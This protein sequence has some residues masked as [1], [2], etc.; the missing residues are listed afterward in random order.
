MPTSTT[1]MTSSMAWFKALLVLSLSHG[2]TGFVIIPAR[3]GRHDTT[4]LSAAAPRMPRDEVP[5]PPE[6]SASVTEGPLTF[7]DSVRDFFLSLTRL[8]LQDYEWRSSYFKSTEADRMLEESL[9]RMQGIR[10]PY[11]RPMDAAEDRMGP[12]GRWEKSSVE[13]L[14]SVIDEEGRR[15]KKIVSNQGKL[16]RPIETADEDDA[17]LG[18]LGF[19][20]QQASDFLNNI[21]QSE[22]ERVRTKT[23]QPKDLP[24]EIRGP[25]GAMEL[26]VS[27]FLREL[28][29][30]EKLRA[31]QSKRRG[32]AMVR[33]IDVPGPLGE[34]E[35]KVAD[36]LRAEERRAKLNRNEGR[37]VR[38]KDA[39]YKGPLGEAEQ[40]IYELFDQLRAE[41]NE[42]LQNIQQLMQDKRPMETDRKS[43]LGV[44]EA[45][46]VG[47]IRAPQLFMSVLQ[48]V[49]ELL[50][51]QP[52]PEE[53]KERL[54]D[55]S[56]LKKD[57]PSQK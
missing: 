33:P 1:T 4:F 55:A 37:V 32:G 29:E 13:W 8:S 50:N 52:L 3:G 18:P 40:F 17:S 24:E 49:G 10:R 9:A 12:L 2:G 48:R 30:S 14:E 53:D 43:A 39:R 46:V 35:L 56:P 11:V 28:R 27:R 5:Q 44:A 6:A 57:P 20:E 38:P 26:T 54:R 21:R 31:E 45:I 41:E 7:Q 25:L 51:S 22:R 16:I 42:R 19:L 23:L 34:W 47:I 15:A 36:I